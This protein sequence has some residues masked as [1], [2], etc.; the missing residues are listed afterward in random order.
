M[1]YTIRGQHIVPR[2]QVYDRLN[3]DHN[4]LRKVQDKG[5]G[6]LFFPL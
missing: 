3:Q 6:K 1:I 4:Y 2:S 5:Q